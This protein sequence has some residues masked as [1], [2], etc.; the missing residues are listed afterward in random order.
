VAC[1]ADRVGSVGIRTGEV[2]YADRITWAIVSI[3]C[4]GAIVVSYG[5][6]VV[7]SK[8]CGPQ[9]PGK[10]SAEIEAVRTVVPE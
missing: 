1:L 6:A 10:L 3:L 7:R 8:G 2:I 5:D 4:A 9:G